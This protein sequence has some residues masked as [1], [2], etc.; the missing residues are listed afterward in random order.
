MKRAVKWGC[1]IGLSIVGV[2]AAAWNAADRWL[3]VKPVVF[4][5]PT[6]G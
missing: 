4:D 1:I 2:G 5:E 6:A 3:H